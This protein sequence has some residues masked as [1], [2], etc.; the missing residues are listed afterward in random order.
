MDNKWLFL[1]LSVMAASGCGSTDPNPA[2]FSPPDI[3]ITSPTDGAT[4]NG[5]VSIDATVTDDF[6][7]DK[8]RIFVD[9]HLL[10][11]QYTPP[12]HTIW[13]TSSETDNSTHVIKIEAQD[14]AKN[15]KT[16]QISVTV[17][18]GPN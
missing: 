3:A 2:D 4:V 1:G 9:S 7:V 8:V 11:E 16:K 14:L 6:G 18:R 12:F 10:A 17:S 5:Q 13:N 15:L